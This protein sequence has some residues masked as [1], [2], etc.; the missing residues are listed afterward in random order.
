ML[1]TESYCIASEC[2][3]PMVYEPISGTT[4][5]LAVEL[6]QYCLAP[7]FSPYD[8][9]RAPGE[10]YKYWSRHWDLP[11]LCRPSPLDKQQAR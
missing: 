8:P 9:S 6:S 3:C 11:D 10:C 4:V 5:S 2:H 1:A 7:W